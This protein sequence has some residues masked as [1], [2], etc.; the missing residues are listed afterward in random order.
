[1][2]NGLL[3]RQQRLA[4]AV[5][6]LVQTGGQVYVDQQGEQRTDSG[7]LAELRHGVVRA[8]GAPLQQVASERGPALAEVDGGQRA[9]RVIGSE[10]AQRHRAGTR[11]HS[12]AATAPATTPTSV[13][14]I[15]LEKT[16]ATRMIGSCAPAAVSAPPMTR[17]HNT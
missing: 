15:T 7:V 10:P 4:E 3:Q 9:Y 1:M 13:P 5:D 8:A 11:R 17:S 14:V 2:G 6:G 16:A 12:P